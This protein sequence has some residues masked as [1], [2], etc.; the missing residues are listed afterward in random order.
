M[1]KADLAEKVANQ[2]GLMKK[3]SREAID[4]TTSVITDALA[5][6][7]KVTSKPR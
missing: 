4:T 1:N 7:E 2:T 5:R 6:G 3:A